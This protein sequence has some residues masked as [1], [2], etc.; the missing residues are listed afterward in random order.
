M[1]RLGLILTIYFFYIG[2]SFSQTEAQIFLD[3]KAN[4]KQSLL[5]DFSYAGYQNG[6]KSIDYSSKNLTVFNV[7][8]FGAVANDN[9]SDKTA[10]K[11]AIAAALANNGGIV[12]FPAGRFI[13]QDATDDLTSYIINKSNIILKGS[14]R[15]S[16][17]TELFMKTPLEPSDPTLFYSTPS[18]FILGGGSNAINPT[19]ITAN[20]VIGDFDITVASTSGLVAGDWL[21]FEMQSTDAASLKLDIGNYTVNPDWTSL[22][23]GG[24]DLSFV[25]QIKKI[26]GNTITLKQP[27]P[28]PIN[29]SLNWKISKYRYTEEMGVE[30]IAFV[31]N[32]QKSFVHHG[33]A[34]DDSG[35]SLL[36][37]KRLVNSWMRNCRFTDVSVGASIGISGANITIDNCVIT[38]NGGHQ[39]INNAG[40]TNVLISNINDQ[41][42]QWHS[43]GVSKTSMNTVLF[44]VTYPATTCF[45]SHASQPRNTLLD[46]VSGG[47]LSNRGGGDISQM[48]NHMRNLVFWNYRKTNTTN[49]SF[50]FWP[51]DPY[52][53]IPFPIVVGFHGQ[54]NT[55]FIQSQLKYQESNGAAVLPT[56]LYNA[57]LQLRLSNMAAGYGEW[58]ANQSIY[59]YNLNGDTGSTGNFTS[60][61]SESSFGSQGFL[62]IPP[63][64]KIKVQVNGTN[65]GGNGFAINNSVNTT[66]PSIIITA[67]SASSLNKFSGYDI[68]NSTEIASM[69]FNINFNSIA[70]NGT[71]VWALGNKNSAGSL[72]TSS[73]AVF[74]ANTELFTSFEWVIKTN[75]IDF[76]FR[77]SA[78]AAT[79]VR[80]LINSTSFGR[81]ANHAVEVYAN[82]SAVSKT[83]IRNEITF[84]VPSN[85]FHIWVNGVQL[86]YNSSFDFP[87]S[88]NTTNTAAVD[89]L[90]INLPLNAYLF[91]GNNSTLPTENSATA[92]ISNIRLNYNAST[93]PVSVGRWV[94]QSAPNSWNYN[95]TSG[96]DAAFSSTGES[97]STSNNSFLPAPPSGIARVFTPSSSIGNAFSL[98]SSQN[99]LE[100]VQ[101]S[102]SGVTKFSAYN[103]SNASEISSMVLNLTFNKAGNNAIPNGTNYILSMGYRGTLN[104]IYSNSNSVFT[105]ANS[106]SNG[107][108]NLFNAIRFIYN[109]TNDEY[110][111]SNRILGNTTG[112][113]ENLD[114]GSLSLNV[115]YRFEIFSNN[116]AISQS[117]QRGN[118]FYNVTAGCYHLWV[119]NLLTNTSN[120]YTVNTTLNYNIPKSVETVSTGPDGNAN[121]PVNTPLNAFLIHGNSGTNGTAKL[122]I[123]GDISMGFGTTTLPVSL[124]SFKGKKE[125]NGIRLFWETSSELNN[126]YFELLRS[127]EG[128]NF[129]TITKVYGKGTSSQLNTYNYLDN[130]PHEGI[131]YYKLKQV[132]KDGSKSV[133]DIIVAINHDLPVHDIFSVQFIKENQLRVIFNSIT[134]GT[135]TLKLFDLSGKIVINKI[136]KTEKGLNTIDFDIPNLNKGVYIAR[137]SQAEIVKSIKILK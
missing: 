118:N 90:E 108:G 113:Y 14:G 80:Q 3:Y 73:S 111:L 128:A 130:Y 65:T 115:P 121:I 38:G 125:V 61:S 49:Q 46:N 122:T 86:S 35:Y 83:Y 74:K 33:S 97:L 101:N 131:N 129:N 6:E 87:K 24:V 106:F 1:S 91:Y 36:Q 55:T 48:P 105:A 82:N 37:F 93:L 77:E 60:G 59:N 135:T 58:S 43:V 41:A 95:F 11:S 42:G 52:W 120:R 17:G 67:N 71:Y 79:S 66:T 63:S 34:L 84:T 104:T 9:I 96:I 2:Y 8:D 102:S 5:P 39:A 72:F 28:Y 75:S 124:L 62:P 114:G 81:G 56:S 88:M 4:P 54:S 22:K 116:S 119:T 123:N 99:K 27:L 50:D 110:E 21:L 137:L 20:A 69:F 25:L 70:T 76:R 98:F 32:F 57:Q 18:L 7:T 107:V 53:K 94:S 30:D 51:S 85:K 134:S 68:E 31:G 23:N 112:Y 89:E 132:D 126:D 47:L 10:I 45:E 40:A 78:D 13:V 44:N 26:V 103:I 29:S 117:Y 136:F 16:G 133:S 100:I 92:T 64:G 127:T 109:S 12:Y 15:G 19:G